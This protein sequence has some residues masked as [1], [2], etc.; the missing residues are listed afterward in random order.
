MLFKRLRVSHSNFYHMFIVSWVFHHLVALFINCY[1]KS[2]VDALYRLRSTA[3]FL[4]M[5]FQNQQKSLYNSTSPCDLVVTS[6]C[7]VLRNSLTL[8]WEEITHWCS[9]LPNMG[10]LCMHHE[11][12]KSESIAPYWRRWHSA[13]KRSRRHRVVQRKYFGPSVIDFFYNQHGITLR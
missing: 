10:G 9:M 2:M 12:C 6:F 7:F 8:R 3:F 5:N 1:L 4:K 11:K 13:L